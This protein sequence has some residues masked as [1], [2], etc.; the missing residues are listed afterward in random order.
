MGSVRDY[1]H[2]SDLA[3]IHPKVSKYLMSKENQIFNCGY[4]KGVR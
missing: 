4:G 2:V 3:D 1:I